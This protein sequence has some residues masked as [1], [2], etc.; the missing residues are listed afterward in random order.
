MYKTLIV[1]DDP[2]VLQTLKMLFEARHFDVSAVPSAQDAISALAT[3]A[4]D[5]V[6]TDMRMET[7]TSGFDVLRTAKNQT[8][9]PVVVI[10][11]AHPIP[12]SDWRRAGADAMF[13]KGGGAS[14][15]LDEIELMLGAQ[16]S[17]QRSVS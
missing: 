16:S 17:Q 14:R 3:T 9:K 6:V 7:D 10:L 1:D 12:A 15:I 8:N 13:I 5:I 4:F 2:A 11:S